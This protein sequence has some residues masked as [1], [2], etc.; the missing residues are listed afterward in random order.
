MKLKSGLIELDIDHL[1]IEFDQMSIKDVNLYLQELKLTKMLLTKARSK[2][3]EISDILQARK[4]ELLDIN[5]KE[6]D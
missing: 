3:L 1:D 4:R 2:A 5:K 6:L